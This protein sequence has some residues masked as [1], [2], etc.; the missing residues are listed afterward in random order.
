MSRSTLAKRFAD[1]LGEPPLT[2]LTRWRM[3]LAAD[4]LAEQESSTIA[5]I[6][7][8]V[9]Y[10]DPFAFSVAFKRVRAP[11]RARSAAWPRRADAVVRSRGRHGRALERFL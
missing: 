8:A 1:L 5:H 11:T 9:G 2:Y 7:R 10:T 3:T 6:A 4:L